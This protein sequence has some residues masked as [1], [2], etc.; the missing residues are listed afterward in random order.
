VVT[1]AA[2]VSRDDA[3]RL[4]RLGVPD[5][6]IQVLG[7][8]RFDSVVDRVGRVDSDESLLGFG[9]GAPTLVAGSTWPPDEDVLLSSFAALLRRRPGARLILV[10][11]EPTPRHIQTIYRRA[12]ALHL[13]EPV[14]LSEATGPVPLLVVDRTGV[15][16]VL[17]GGGSM[18]FVGG[19]F[20][21]A[22]LHSVLEPAAWGVPVTFG[23]RWRNSRDAAQLLE[24][25][26]ASALP[27]ASRR[28]AATALQEVW[29][30]WVADEER[31]SAQGQRARAVI[32]R[33]TG[34]SSR[35]AEMLAGLI[36][37][38]RL[39]RSRPAAR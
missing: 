20:G 30:P 23:P 27:Y 16:A 2:A 4:A 19:G 37:E 8:P 26:A 9:R 13:P 29:E 18:A 15:L 10:P 6:R 28:R 14:R 5:D 33:G 24:G 36:S 38:R 3:V 7:D 22:G 32:E 11:H 31:R 35:S 1:A 12:A 39:R 25:D 34:A 21:R 17:Y